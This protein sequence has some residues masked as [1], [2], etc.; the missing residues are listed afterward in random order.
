MKKILLSIAIIFGFNIVTDNVFSSE[1]E[2]NAKKKITM[3]QVKNLSK[4][5]KLPEDKAKIGMTYGKLKNYI[6]M[7]NWIVVCLI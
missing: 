6:Q 4:K 7:E 3:T 2:A 5:G 1:M